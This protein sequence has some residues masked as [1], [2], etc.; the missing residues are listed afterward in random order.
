MDA[1]EFRQA[2]HALVDWISS[3]LEGLDSLPVSSR[4]RPGEIA[5]ALRPRAPG[6]PRG[7]D[8]VLAELEEVVVPGLTHW[9]H[10]SFF[11]YFPANTS[12]ASILGDLACAGLGVNGMSWA[13]SPACTEVEQVT[14]DW[15]ADLLGL[16]PTMR[17]TGPGGGV[18]QDSASSATLCAILAARERATGGSGNRD[19]I[20][21]GR[22]VAYASEQAHISVEKGMRIAGL[23]SAA[24][25]RVPVGEDF[26]MRPDAL[27]EML[28]ADEAAGLTP[29][30][31]VATSGTTSSLAFDPLAEIA[32]IARLHGAW[33]HVDAA[34][35]GMAA[36]CPEMRFVLEGVEEVDSWCTNPHKWMGVGFDC[37]LL[38]VADRRPLVNALSLQAEYL[39]TPEAESGSAVDYRDWQVPLGRRFRSLKLLFVLRLEGPEP[40]REMLRTHVSLAQ[41]LAGWASSDRRFEVVA[42][43][44]LNLVCLALS[45]G[46]GPTRSLVEDANLSGEALFTRT[47]LAGREVLRVCVGGRTTTRR[48][49]EAAWQ[50]LAR[51]AG[52]P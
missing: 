19:G 18:I 39:R 36:L 12:Y 13:T 49:V 11:A 10:P 44:P 28:S 20:A 24:L 50:L 32:P 46:D 2:G 25:R 40:I 52:A 31:V 7:F 47:V 30:L 37:D 42:P 34:M 4:A 26:A 1:H 35:S 5:A 17:S 43:H 29:F 6:A 3:Y 23:G 41:E 16:P 15:M 33:V 45:A 51:L 8:E 27:A 48:H 38:Y 22:L 9:Q 14:C 21:R